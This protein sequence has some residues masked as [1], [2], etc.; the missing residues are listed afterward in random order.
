MPDLNDVVRHVILRIVVD[1]AGL[2]EEMAAA[3]AKLRALQ[4][5]EKQSN[6]ERSKDAEKVSNALREQNKAL[7]ENRK[8]HE[9]AQRA[10]QAGG[11]AAA[12]EQKSRTAAVKDETKAVNARTVAEATAAKLQSE[13]AKTAAQTSVIEQRAAEVQERRSRAAEQE[14]RATQKRADQQARASER[15]AAQE[16]KAAADKGV[17]AAKQLRLDK[18]VA[19]QQAKIAAAAEARAVKAAER[20]AKAQ[21][22]ADARAVKAGTTA[23]FRQVNGPEDIISKAHIQ[24]ISEDA[25]RA[26]A[27]EQQA[28]AQIR[29]EERAARAAAA[30][31]R[32]NRRGVIGS[33][34][35][36]GTDLLIGA[37]RI[38]T[39]SA[40]S[41]FRGT[42]RRPGDSPSAGLDEVGKTASRAERVVSA[43]F[44]KFRREAA[45]SEKAVVSLSGRFK[46]FFEDLNRPRRSGSGGL[47][48]DIVSNFLS[49][50]DAMRNGVQNL[51]R[52]FLSW[53][54]LIAA[55]IVALGPLAAI[56]GAVGAAA[57]GLAS[58]FVALIG[59]FA[60]LPGIIGAAVAGFG[61]LAIVMKPLSNVFSAFSAAQAEAIKT[62]QAARSASLSYTE[63][64]LS[65][66]A[67]QLAYQ[68]AVQ[69]VPRSQQNLNQARR[70][71][72]RT[73][74]DYR[75]QLQKLKYDEESATL[76]VLSSEQ[77]YRRALADP[78]ASVLDRAIARN[79]VQGALFDQR[80]QKVAGQRLLQDSSLAFKKGVEGA[81]E[82]VAAERAVQDATL[83]VAQSYVQWQKSIIAVSQAAQVKLAGGSA[84]AQLQAELAQLPP[85][86]RK[87]A[88]AIIGLLRGP[89][90]DMRTALSENI[91][92]PVSTETGKFADVLD[93]LRSFMEPA[94]V[95]LGKLLQNALDLLTNPEWKKFFS[96]QG[97]ESGKIFSA[98]GDAALKFGNAFRSLIEIA[99]PFTT[100]VV[101]GI[102]ALATSFDKFATSEQGRKSLSDFLSTTQ[103]RIHE[104][105]PVV[106]NFAAG[107]VGFFQALNPDPKRAG[108]ED[109]TTWFNKGLLNIS[110][111]FRKLG[112][113]ARDPN[114]GFQKWLT[115]VK[116]LLKE[117][118]GFLSAAGRFF[119]RLFSDPSNMKE[120][121]ALL[122]NIS[123]KWLPGLATIFDNLSKSGAISKLAD[124]IG[125]IVR[126]V[127]SFAQSGG[128]QGLGAIGTV[129]K[130]IAG[131]ISDVVGAIDWLS[132]HVKGFHTAFKA[133]SIAFG[134]VFGAALVASL[135]R[136]DTLIFRI[137]KGLGVVDKLKNALPGGA[138]GKA[139]GVVN[140][141]TG[142]DSN[143]AV[144]TVLR[145]MEAYLRQ[146]AINTG[147]AGS[148]GNDL[149]DGE[150]EGKGGKHRA[151]DKLASAEKDAASAAEKDVAGTA[152]R[153]R[154]GRL[155]R[156]IPWRRGVAASV[157]EGA[158]ESAV[159]S[160]ATGTGKPSVLRRV[161]SKLWPSGDEGSVGLPERPVKTAT[162]AVGR[163]AATTTA[164][165]VAETA[166]EAGGKSLLARGGSAFLRGARGGIVSA[167][168]G[169]AAQLGGDYLINRTVKNA[170]DR[171]SL[172]RGL[173][174][175]ATGAGIGATIGSV[176]PGLGTAV[177][178]VVGG[179][180]AGVYSL[181]RDK[182]LRHFVGSKI[183][184]GFHGVEN[185]LAGGDRDKPDS[186]V[187][188]AGLVAGPVGLLA[189]AVA[190]TDIGKSILSSVKSAA[191]GVGDF[192]T[193][194]VPGFARHMASSI[195]DF[196]T[197]TLP[198]L[199]GKAFDF[200]FRLLGRVARFFVVDLPKAVGN[201]FTK[202][203]PHFAGV[204]FDFVFRTIGRL[205]RFF[206]VDLPRTISI[207][208]T[209][210]IP[211]NAAAAWSWI[212]RT[213]W[214][215]F[216]AF[217]RGIPGFFTKTIPHWFETGWHWF[218]QH[219]VSPLHRFIFESVPKFF[220]DTIPKWFAAAPHWFKTH[221]IDPITN[222]FTQTLPNFFT[223]TLPNAIA[224]L[225][226]MLY[227]HI[228]KPITGFFQGLKA[229]IHIS[230]LF[231]GAKDLWNWA[232]GL[233]DRA[234]AD[235][236]EGYQGKMSGG[237]VTGI[238]Q[239][240]EDTARVM[241]TPEE[242]VVRRSK[243]VQ[244]YGKQFLS[245]YNEGRIDPAIF[246][247]GLSAATAPPVM[248]IVPPNVSALTG[249]VPTI[250]NHTVNHAPL[251][252]DV[253]IHNPVREAAEFSLRRQ[254]QI[255]NIRHRR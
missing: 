13:A 135:T 186:G 14:A 103:Q 173:G 229:H 37:S 46:A 237:L 247:R 86:T 157:A 7:D 142:G 140:A 199:P 149:P 95:A 101:G 182:N 5:A 244:P 22:A 134:L 89:Y 66:K 202:T 250:V 57:L 239:G 102:E 116:P 208:F 111:T 133:L 126:A 220:T 15:A 21:A 248:S 33:A 117:V 98:L 176:I 122:K 153:S 53:Q 217:V 105:W 23:H 225:P 231:T 16:A 4:D 83:N 249:A 24:A 255:A 1:Q 119:G 189:A 69:D 128:F 58:N 18:D 72:A 169:T 47:G 8:T 38:P 164:A 93:E 139:A 84:A 254:V 28:A 219:I 171:A 246:Y 9:A 191:G 115:N 212:V 129:F 210:T 172:S 11:R 65:E 48:G 92:G 181:A 130:T 60:A 64:L 253:T 170:D 110:E 118:V 27:E 68:R 113:Q 26:K 146:I 218:Q 156:L 145:R 215:P 147:G 205:A 178:G 50:A 203:L 56:L 123:T 77:D 194:T 137:L 19:D 241:A 20:D 167:V 79:R 136:I 177:G 252:G 49:M 224:S 141:L 207:F 34:S 96:E 125:S 221:V 90:K 42:S 74:Q 97:T 62:T 108:Q 206:L 81:D 158:A 54:T 242:F 200:F 82:V 120:A 161:L 51:S 104:L 63:A 138:S 193:K 166:A 25:R 112:E 121:E 213:L 124:G 75:L 230:D 143:T 179:A 175:V 35:R 31:A 91:F 209:Q 211:H 151:K 184:S 174:A 192:F 40:V 127:A 17:R 198:S 196:F 216:V 204:A 190:K 160:A 185:F 6:K 45:D 197:K 88:E 152:S 76:G 235:T 159:E 227:N 36:I 2:A 187:A 245:D 154:F 148:L 55:V 214:N 243:V 61:A 44:G 10:G 195:G 99:R 52:H 251:M 163:R 114:S 41:F 32:R 228:V 109:F 155:R 222:F 165:G 12:E 240:I 236:Q 132:E 233:F 29:Q 223:K 85:M 30:E 43:F 144:V 71:A 39:T 107:L 100:F 59:T 234:S 232:K 168:L 106:K 87:V 80:D 70:Q 73:I 162:V 94:S 201:F 180:I 3:R 188:K 78:T 238:Y 226:G 183:S 150:D 131:G 67:A